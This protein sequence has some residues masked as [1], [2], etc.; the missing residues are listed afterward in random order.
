MSIAL[1]MLLEDVVLSEL[2]ARAELLSTERMDDGL[3][4]MISP[5]GSRTLYLP[6]APLN[7]MASA[8]LPLRSGRVISPSMTTTSPISSP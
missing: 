1:A 2:F 6:V 7:P 8:A 5:M 4:A 3:S